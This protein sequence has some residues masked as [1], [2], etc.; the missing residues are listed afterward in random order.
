[1]IGK[2]GIV[3]KKEKRFR[4]DFGSKC[5]DGDALAHVAQRSY[6]CPIPGSV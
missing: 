3:I 2:W 5:E 1:M 6:E 4:L